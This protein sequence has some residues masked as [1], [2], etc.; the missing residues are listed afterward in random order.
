MDPYA[1]AKWIKRIVVV[2]V[3]L[4]VF[5]IDMTGLCSF[6]RNSNA[7]IFFALFGVLGPNI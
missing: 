6:P 5:A 4:F 1:K 2:L 7:G 3:P